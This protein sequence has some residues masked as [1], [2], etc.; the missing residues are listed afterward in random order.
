MAGIDAL[1]VEMLKANKLPANFSQDC[2]LVVERA[3]DF[4]CVIFDVDHYVVLKWQKSYRRWR[5]PDEKNTFE[6]LLNALHFI[7]TKY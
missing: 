7:S 4:I 3:N 2:K 6:D 1:M 5:T